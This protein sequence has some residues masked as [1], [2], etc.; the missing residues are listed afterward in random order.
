M[1]SGEELL[2]GGG[3]AGF[4]VDSGG[5]ELAAPDWSVLLIDAAD[6]GEDAGVKRA[7]H[8]GESRPAGCIA[9]RGGTAA[10][11]GRPDGPVN[12]A[13]GF[14]D[15][16]AGESGREAG[17]AGWGL[18]VCGRGCWGAE[19]CAEARMVA[20]NCAALRGNRDGIGEEHVTTEASEF[21]ADGEAVKEGG[22]E[23]GSV[24]DE[25]RAA[26]TATWSEMTNS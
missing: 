11:I 8:G 15:C 6:S 2:T 14:G 19:D 12:G 23:S 3:A 4:G 16:R 1:E 7:L 26:S 17:G 25:F 24:G 22:T 13:A 5:A 9:V 10:K 20:A 18:V 21:W